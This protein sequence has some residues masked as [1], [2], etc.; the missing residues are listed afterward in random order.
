MSKA[1]VREDAFNEAFDAIVKEGRDDLLRNSA[2]LRTHIKALSD[3]LHRAMTES[4]IEVRL[5]YKT[6]AQATCAWTWMVTAAAR[7]DVF[8][9]EKSSA[10]VVELVNGSAIVFQTEENTVAPLAPAD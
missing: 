3:A 8:Q 5:T 4:D 1:L 10:F 7:K 2:V 6:V 9:S